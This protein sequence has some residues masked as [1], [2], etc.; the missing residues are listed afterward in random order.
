MLSTRVFGLAC[1]V[2]V[3]GCLMAAPVSA[4]PLAQANGR[5]IVFSSSRR[6]RRPCVAR[7]RSRHSKQLHP[8]LCLGQFHTVRPGSSNPCRRHRPGS[9]IAAS[10]RAGWLSSRGAV[11]SKMTSDGH[12]SDRAN[13]ALARARPVGRR[14]RLSDLGRHDCDG[15]G[16]LPSQA[17]CLTGATGL[18]CRSARNGSGTERRPETRGIRGSDWPSRD[19]TDR[20]LGSRCGRRR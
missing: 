6:R 15:R 2:A 8:R 9:K 10:A 16:R 18:L 5:R 3:C 14:S 20:T 1:A 17:A 12:D 4:Q 7:D 13:C 19:S 11:A